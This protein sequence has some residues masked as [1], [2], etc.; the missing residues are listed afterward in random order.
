MDGFNDILDIF[1]VEDVKMVK[2]KEMEKNCK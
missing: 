1:W 2:D